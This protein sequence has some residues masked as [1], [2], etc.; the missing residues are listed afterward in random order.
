MIRLV[1][2][3]LYLTL[4]YSSPSRPERVAAVCQELGI[5]CQPIDFVRPNVAAEELYTVENGR[6]ALHQRTPEERD[7]FYDR[8][9]ALLLREAGLPGDPEV[10]RRVRTAMALRAG[11]W[12]AYDDV[13]PSL[14]ELRR[15]GLALGVISNTATDATE[16]C[17]TLG[18]CGLVD[19]IV[20][21]CLVG[22]EK[23]CRR[24]FETALERAGVAPHEAVH[25]GD[26]PR[27]DVLGALG[28]GMHALLLDR[29]GLLAHE[30]YERISSLAEIPPW[31]DRQ[32]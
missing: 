15:R 26:Q 12:L 20:S 11:Q 22:C 21:S 1:T 18:V 6:H 30:R 24:I 16:L 10:V 28:A 25:V 31:L 17:D 9:W 27:S 4:C 2:L 23:P 7:A 14:S 3:D 13:V 29:H 19:F 32:F 5:A 8:M